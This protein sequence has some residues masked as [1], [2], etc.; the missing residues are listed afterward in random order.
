MDG[1]VGYKMMLVLVGKVTETKVFA[2]LS[3]TNTTRSRG[4]AD[5]RWSG[6][7]SAPTETE[8]GAEGGT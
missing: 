1:S 6:V 5:A 4:G 2:A 7:C 8:N 3:Y